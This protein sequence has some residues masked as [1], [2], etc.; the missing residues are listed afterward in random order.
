MSCHV[1]SCHVMSCHIM[2]YFILSNLISPIVFRPSI[3]PSFL[4]FFPFLCCTP[5]HYTVAL[6]A[7]NVGG[8]VAD[9]CD[10]VAVCAE[11]N[12]DVQYIM[13]VAQ[14]VPTT[15][16][17][18]MSCT[19]YHSFIHSFC[20][21]E[22]IILCHV[23]FFYYQFSYLILSYLILSNQILSY[24]ILS[25]PILSDLII[26]YPILSDLILSYHILSNLIAFNFILS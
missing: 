13:A 12:L 22:L 5:S 4:P 26:S 25:Y 15:Y 7:Y 16:V 17:P 3:L 14:D 21:T 23:F 9:T 19:Y 24:L 11:A 6:P 1:M 20:F 18:T 2:S 10:G 8:H